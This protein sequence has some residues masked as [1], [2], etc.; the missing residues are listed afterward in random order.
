MSPT[1]VLVL[2]LVLVLVVVVVPPPFP[3]AQPPPSVERTLRRLFL[4]LFLRGR[5][6]RGLKKSTTPTSVWQ[7]LGL[8]LFFYAVFG[9]MAAVSLHHQPLFALSVYLHALTFVFLGMFVAASA[10]EIL[11]N[12]EE[13]D[14][15]LHRPIAPRTMLWAKIRV[16][17]EVSLWLAGALNLAGF[18]VGSYTPDGGWLYAPAH[19]VSTV[20]EALFCTSCVVLVYQLCLRWAG[21]ERLDGLMTTAQVLMAVVAVVGGQVVPRV[22]F[23]LEGV[24]MFTSKSW[25]VALLPP[26]WF[27]GLDDAL[28]GTHAAN[29]WLLAAI[30]LAGTVIVVWLAFGKLAGGY[31]HGLQAIGETVSRRKP[32]RAGHRWLDLLVHTPPLSWFLREPVTRASFLL[33]LACLVRDRDVKLRVYPGIAPMMVMPFIFLFQPDHH[34]G[35]FFGNFGVGFASVYLGILPMLGMSMLQYSQQWAASDIFRAAPMAGPKPLCDGARLAVMCVLALP[36]LIV[37]A[38]IVGLAHGFGSELLLL[39]PGVISLPVY[40]LVPC[41]GGSGVPLSLPTEEAKSASRG[42]MMLPVML[43]SMAVAGIALWAWQT[44]WFW[45]FILVETALVA[46]IYTGMRAS[47]AN[48]KWEPME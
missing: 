42:L 9:A 36:A 24:V 25:W 8:V 12:K 3:K 30:A 6:S 34:G 26:A 4:T 40:G 37:F 41:L 19:A 27:A 44:G 14:I 29:S 1:V 11:F 39:L 13:A 21:R 47:L 48:A 2:V 18:V 32:R 22:M 45:W 38:V 33:T 31:E 15:L 46:V 43:I 7:K 20:A 28:A 35:G 17:I 23:R 10:G 16:L 5:S